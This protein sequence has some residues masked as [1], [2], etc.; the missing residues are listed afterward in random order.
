MASHSTDTDSRRIPG[1]DPMSLNNQGM[2][3]RSAQSSKSTNSCLDRSRP[4][5]QSSPL[6]NLPQEIQDRIWYFYYKDCKEA[7]V[8][9]R[10]WYKRGKM[11][12]TISDLGNYGV[13]TY[14]L[15]LSLTCWKVNNDTRSIRC[16]AG[17]VLR[18]CYHT[19]FDKLGSIL[20][21][22]KLA[23]KFK[24]ITKICITCIDDKNFR[25]FR[26]FL[27]HSLKAIANEL[28]RLY[29]IK[30]SCETRKPVYANHGR[31]V[32]CHGY[33]KV[34]KP[35]YCR[36]LK[37]GERD[38]DYYEQLQDSRVVDLAR[39]LEHCGK[40]ACDVLFET[41]VHWGPSPV[42]R[43]FCTSALFKVTSKKLTGIDYR[44]TCCCHWPQ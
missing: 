8:K 28:V 39:A 2:D 22:E 25:N 33:A 42:T 15:S 29:E 24:N 7:I 32:Y 37:R 4:V 34:I 14:G 10:D 6:L 27:I 13:N 23:Q 12:I 18:I 40:F 17:L 21:H 20:S 26:N 31:Q 44:V 43:R 35:G 19:N 16:R 5:E 36:A 38:K 30:I 1:R 41:H 3:M 9:H 11:I